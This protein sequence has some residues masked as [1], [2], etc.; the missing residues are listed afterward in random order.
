[1]DSVDFGD[2][3]QLDYSTPRKVYSMVV[4]QNFWEQMLSAAYVSLF[5]L[6]LSARFTLEP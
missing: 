5:G 2:A 6:Q 3:L 4:E 1:M